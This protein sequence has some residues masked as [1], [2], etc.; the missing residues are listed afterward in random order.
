MS[1]MNNVRRYDFHEMVNDEAMF[2][3]STTSGPS[4][5]SPKVATESDKDSTDAIPHRH[6]A[7]HLARPAT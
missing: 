3:V 1:D 5:P 6:C 4:G 7:S 2:L